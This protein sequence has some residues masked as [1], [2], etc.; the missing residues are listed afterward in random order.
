V[1][2]KQEI[3]ITAP[4][5]PPTLAALDAEFVTHRLWEAK[6]RAAFLAPLCDRVT[7]IATM[8]ETGTP[9]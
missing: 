4:M 8:G 5:Y 1:P 3:V 9:R 2:A 7:A 6:D